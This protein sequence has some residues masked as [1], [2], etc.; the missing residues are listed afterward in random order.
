MSALFEE[1]FLLCVVTYPPALGG[2]R[3]PLAT[4]SPISNREAE[5]LQMQQLFQK[6]KMKEV[7][8]SFSLE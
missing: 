6:Q 7:L 3:A 5:V 4:L 1:G 2:F 8:K